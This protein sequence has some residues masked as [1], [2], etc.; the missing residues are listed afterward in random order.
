LYIPIRINTVAA[1]IFLHFR[2]KSPGSE[3][4]VRE[5]EAK[6]RIKSLLKNS[7]SPRLIK[8][9]QMQGARNPE[10]GVTTNKE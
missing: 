8:N 9:A 3:G 7:F 2:G 10:S 4:N 6:S 5:I 1:Q